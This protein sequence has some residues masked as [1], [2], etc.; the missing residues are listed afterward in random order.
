MVTL[1]RKLF[2]E[3]YFFFRKYDAANLNFFLQR[4]NR[5]FWLLF[6]VLGLNSGPTPCGTPPALFSDGFFKIGSHK[7][8]AQAGFE[9]QS[10]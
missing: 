6:V 10:S 2:I 3:K 9:S 1:C 4:K 7:L 5:T 8:F